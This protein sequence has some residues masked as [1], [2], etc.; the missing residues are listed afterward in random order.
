MNYVKIIMYTLIKEEL[1]SFWRNNQ[2][3]TI[4][5]FCYNGV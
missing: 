5:H 4:I 2:L 3:K 1:Q